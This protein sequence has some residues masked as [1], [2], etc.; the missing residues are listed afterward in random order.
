MAEQERNT[1]KGKM[2]V[3]KIKRRIAAL[4]LICCTVY[5]TGLSGMKTQMREVQAETKEPE[6]L[7]AQSA[8][9]MDAD[10]GRILFSKNGQQE[11]AMASTTKIMT[12]ILALEYGGLDDKMSVSA[13]AASQPQVHLGAVKGEEFYLR[14]LLY[15]LMLESHNDSAVIIAENVG[16]SVEGFA[17]MMNAKAK[18]LGCKNTYFITPNGLDASDEKGSHHTTAEDLARIMKYCIMDSPEKDMF[19]EVTRTS[20]YQFTDCSG[21]HSYSC[22][23]H[24]AFLQMMKGALS[25][26]TGFTGDAGYCYVGSLKD[27]GRTFI[28]AL[29]ACGWPNNKSYK[30]ADTKAL[31]NYGLEHYE[32]RNIRQDVPTGTLKVYHG[33][34]SQN[35]FEPET[36]IP[37]EV[38]GTAE[39][40]SI[41]LRDDEKVNVNW[42]K[43]KNAE[44][45]VGKGEKVG[46]VR[47]TLNG[48]LLKSYDIVSGCSIPEKNAAWYIKTIF[49]LYFLQKV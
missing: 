38:A 41:L 49:R 9:L 27:K 17:D 46:E 44:A 42:E 29:L 34:D 13:Y 5:V 33:V 14:D 43:K 7:Y 31:M 3:L 19:L 25:G 22:T 23:N 39:N 32:Y 4:I 26:K 48:E 10:S 12:C 16:K 1:D 35:P 45:P 37:L 20:N 21:K 36:E 18:E 15:S 28:V 40:W 30:W 11:R 6:N 47:Y 8:V 24:N 2:T